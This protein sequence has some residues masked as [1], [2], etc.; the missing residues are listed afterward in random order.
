[1]KK[2]LMTLVSAFA[3]VSMNAQTNMYIGGSLGYS[4]T[5]HD[6]STLNTKFSFIPH[7]GVRFTDTMGVGVE[8]GYSSN[9]NE[10][11]EPTVT[12]SE[13]TF[14]PYFRYTAIKMGNLAFF[15]DGKFGYTTSKDEYKYATGNTTDM[16]TNSW[17]LYVQPGMAYS[18]NQNFGLV[19][20]FGNI[21]GY[22]SS[23]PD[24]SGAKA[25]SKFEFLNL[26][27][28]IQFGVF[29]NF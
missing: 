5:S 23:K 9:K 13:F 8:I 19:A 16:T 6:G 11:S 7:F 29:Y 21:L 26:S 25:T 15:G 24:V 3:A 28:N 27:N 2:I 14:A 4:T 22:T 20:K 10:K 1:M 18:L 12:T 17:G